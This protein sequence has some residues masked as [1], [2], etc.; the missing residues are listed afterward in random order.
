[1]KKINILLVLVSLLALNSC[2]DKKNNELVSPDLNSFT[3]AEFAVID[4]S[5]VVNG[6]E[7]ATIETDIVCNDLLANYSFMG[8]NP[9]TMGGG[10]SFM[11]G[12]PGLRGNAWFDKFNPVKHLERILVKLRLNAEQRTEVKGFLL[13]YHNNMKPLVKSY[14][15]ASKEIIKD[16]NLARKAIIADLRAGTITRE[17]AKTRIHALNLETKDKIKN[18]PANIALKDEMCG[19]RTRLFGSIESILTSEQKTKWNNWVNSIPDPC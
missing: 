9:S 17:E 5:D 4:Y 10:M 12:G 19:E 13:T 16:A 8:T 18:N 3:S 15:E 2:S 1:M 11:N 6:I 14:F 7:D